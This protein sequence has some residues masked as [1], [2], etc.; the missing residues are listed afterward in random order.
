MFT[1]RGI[2]P[3]VGD[4]SLPDL[5]QRIIA[6]GINTVGFHAGG[7]AEATPEG[8]IDFITGERGRAVLRAFA[9]AGVDIE[10][11]LH[12]MRWLLPRGLFE[13]SPE[14][15]RMDDTGVRTPDANLCCSS[16]EA[17]RI[18]SQRAVQ[19]CRILR[20]TTHRYFLWADDGQPWCQCPQ[21]RGLSP[22][23]Q[24]LVIANA[25]AGALR[26]WDPRARLAAL[27]YLQTLDPPRQVK[28][29]PNVFLEFA[30]IRRDSSRALTDPTSEANAQMVAACEAAIEFF[31]APGA[32]VLEYWIDASRA[33]GWK[34]PA[35]KLPYDG[36]V[37]RKDL[38]FYET[39]GF[40]SVTSFSCWIDADYVDRW[41]DPPLNDYAAALRGE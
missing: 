15:F 36:S 38:R 11:E 40:E 16:S 29:A 33:S 18:V 19:L 35:A 10:Y 17:L 27:T 23:D 9:E 30:P 34:R 41:G 24:N 31:G 32:H 6:A 37:L 3:E 20:S 12:A 25:I 39:L 4:F 14:L 26:E 8:A 13:R 5:E 28:P 2:V 1:R 7:G 22:S 21:C